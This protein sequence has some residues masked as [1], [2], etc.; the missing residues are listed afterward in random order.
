MQTRAQCPE[1]EICRHSRI[2]NEEAAPEGQ[3]WALDTWHESCGLEALLEALQGSYKGEIFLLNFNEIRYI[4]SSPACP[5]HPALGRGRRGSLAF[6]PA[7]CWSSMYPSPQSPPAHWI[8][9]FRQLFS[10]FGSNHLIKESWDRFIRLGSP[11]VE[12]RPTSPPCVL[13][14]SLLNKQVWS[15]FEG[16]PVKSGVKDDL[17]CGIKCQMHY[18]LIIND[19]TFVWQLII[20]SSFSCVW[21]CAS[22]SWTGS[23]CSSVSF[24]SR[25]KTPTAP[26]ETL[27]S[28]SEFVGVTSSW[29]KISGLSKSRLVPSQFN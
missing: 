20:S 15:Y 17:W 21:S 12:A 7:A 14:L 4:T 1:T 22:V 13:F 16:H 28:S 18:T 23:T 10:L 25:L 3:G 29:V 19:H 8:D 5:T 9:T 27:S 6:S 2:E 24:W 26:L 11:D